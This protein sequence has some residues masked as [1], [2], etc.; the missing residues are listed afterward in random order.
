MYTVYTINKNLTDIAGVVNTMPVF[1][2]FFLDFNKS[3]D[4]KFLYLAGSILQ[5]SAALE[6]TVSVS[7]FLVL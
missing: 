1:L 4:D 5:I 2:F 7:Y 3:D 6:A